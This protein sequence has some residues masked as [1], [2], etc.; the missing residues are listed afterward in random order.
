MGAGENTE[1][2]TPQDVY[3]INETNKLEN[4]IYDNIDNGENLVTI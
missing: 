2:V 3:G 4:D 1:Y